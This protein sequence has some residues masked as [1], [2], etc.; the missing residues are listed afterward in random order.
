MYARTMRAES[1]QE[2]F[3]VA[4][5]KLVGCQSRFA[6]E[7]TANRPKGQK[8]LV[9]SAPAPVLPDV[10]NLELLEKALGQDADSIVCN[11]ARL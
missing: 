11:C 8:R 2:R 5:N 3:E 9:R 6:A 1:P 4:S 7:T 10:Q